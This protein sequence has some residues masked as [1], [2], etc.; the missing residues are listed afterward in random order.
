M[1]GVLL[2]QATARQLANSSLMPGVS[3]FRCIWRAPCRRELFPM[4]AAMQLQALPQYHTRRSGRQQPF[5]RKTEHRIRK[6]PPMSRPAAAMNSAILPSAFTV[7]V[8]I[9]GTPLAQQKHMAGL[10]KEQVAED[11]AAAL[12]EVAIQQHQA[13]RGFRAPGLELSLVLCDDEVITEL[14][15]QYRGKDEPTDVLSFP[16]EDFLPKGVPMRILGDVVISLDT[17]S[18]QAAEREVGLREECRVLLVHGLLHLVG[19]DHEEGEEEAR[20]MAA[21]EKQLLSK[22]G[23]VG[24]GLIASAADASDSDGGSDT[25][26]QGGIGVKGS[27]PPGSTGGPFGDP[28]GYP[29]YQGTGGT[30]AQD[31]DEATARKGR[32]KRDRDIKLVA[33]DMDG[34]LL[35]SRSQILPSSVEVVRAA[36]AAGVRVCL[37]TGKARPA[38]MSALSRVG[39]SGEGL[40]VSRTG[41]G[42]FLQGLAVHCPKGDL[43]EGSQL[44][45][46]V[47]ERAFQFSLQQDISLCAFLG[48]HTATLKMTGELRELHERY[49]E[50]LAEVVAS[51]PELLEGPPVKKLLF[52]ADPAVLDSHLKPFWQAACE[53]TGAEVMQAVPNM[54]ELVPRGVNKWVGMQSLL[55]ALGLR[56]EEVMACGDGGNDL[57]LVANVGLGVAMGNAV[58]EVLEA[59]HVVVATNDDGG[60]AE[61]FEKFVL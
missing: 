37:A 11:A 36:L 14:N 5:R 4:P 12:K 8:A 31:A 9:E 33:L 52:M 48:D 20:R 61:A 26:S 42:I 56:A 25:S 53:G 45:M 2:R 18:R 30:S 54:L 60:I 39:L 59:A 29:G 6:V 35:D 44:D 23:W 50:P 40:V 1:W 34:T 38:A 27:A 19:Y 7:D 58:P 16:I 43:I 21:A 28:G 49:Y 46:A 57:H 47:V 41:P 10:L 15:T 32:R 3:A 55:P 22:L 24:E 17:A 13:G 51:L